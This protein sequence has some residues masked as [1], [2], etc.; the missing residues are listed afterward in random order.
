MLK[1]AWGLWFDTRSE[2]DLRTRRCSGCGSG[3]TLLKISDLQKPSNKSGRYWV[4]AGTY[5]DTPVRKVS[6]HPPQ[7]ATVLLLGWV[8]TNG[9]AEPLSCPLLGQHFWATHC[10]HLL[11][12]YNKWPQTGWLNTTGAA[13]EAGSLKSSRGELAPQ[14]EGT[15][16]PS[17]SFSGSWP[18]GSNLCLSPLWV[19][20]VSVLIPCF[21]PTKTLR[22]AFRTQLE[23]PYLK[24]LSLNTCAKTH[25]PNK[26]TFT[27]LRD[28]YLMPL[29]GDYSTYY[30]CCKS[31]C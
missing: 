1:S 4:L 9:T 24:I 27:N 25:F 31:G 7:S 11:A 19:L 17:P 28:G 20:C 23:S 14:G 30:T 13:L 21:S 16:L 15:A 6:P 8:I 22:M 29:G 12:S 3:S 10:I 26:V 2:Q 18:H 5:C